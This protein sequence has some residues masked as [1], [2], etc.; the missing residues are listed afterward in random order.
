MS[1]AGRFEVLDPSS[2]HVMKTIS[3]LINNQEIVSSYLTWTQVLVLGTGR[4]LLD[5]PR[6]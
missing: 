4:C 2:S 3:L 5:S 1:C 6:T